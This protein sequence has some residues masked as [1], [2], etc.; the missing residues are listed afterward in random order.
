MRWEGAW[1]A[2]RLSYCEYE[3]PALASFLSCSLSVGCVRCVV[4]T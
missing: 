1:R 2:G 3:A 4:V